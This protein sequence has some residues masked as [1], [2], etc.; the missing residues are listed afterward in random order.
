MTMK[1]VS[2]NLELSA[3]M[4]P[5]IFARWYFVWHVIYLGGLFLTTGLSISRLWSNW[6]GQGVLLLVGVVVLTAVYTLT[7]IWK[8]PWPL[9]GWWKALYFIISIATWLAITHFSPGFV[10][11]V[12]VYIFH[13]FTILSPVVAIPVVVFLIFAIQVIDSVGEGWAVLLAALGQNLVGTAVSLSFTFLIYGFIRNI[14][15]TNKQQAKLVAQLQKAQH[16]LKIAHQQESELAVLQERERLARDLHDGLGHSLVALSLQLEAIQRLY[17]VDPQRAS[18]QVDEMKVVTREATLALRRSLAGLRAPGL[19]KRPLRQAI[20]QIC[21]EV[22]E[23]TAAQVSWQLADEADSLRPK[24]AE[25]IWRV[26]QEALTN[27][28]KH[29]QAQQVQV[30]LKMTPDLVT[31]LVQDDGVGLT[32]VAE[33]KPGHYGI[34]GMRERVEGLGGS[35]QLHSNG[36]GGTQVQLQIPLL[37]PQGKT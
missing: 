33:N 24:I 16:E 19:G 6:S 20:E 23:R 31:L 34:R 8:R 36:Q 29:A 9:S 5:S 30:A 7:F 35:F 22:G 27:V 18:A 12:T 1:K 26:T 15:S 10:W 21:V 37:L 13:T 32:A 3:S 17:P 14:M 25:A 28:E 4:Q 2:T 11:L